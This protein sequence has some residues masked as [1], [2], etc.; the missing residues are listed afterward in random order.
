MIL[1]NKTLN[2]LKTPNRF[3]S[4]KL[5]QATKPKN[6]TSDVTW[7]M[8]HVV[9]RKQI[10]YKYL[11]PKRCGLFGGVLF[12]EMKFVLS[13]CLSSEDLSISYES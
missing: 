10:C 1:Q 5:P 8:R 9:Q 12:G 7:C 4:L 13:N 6:L 11:N 2:K 3:Y